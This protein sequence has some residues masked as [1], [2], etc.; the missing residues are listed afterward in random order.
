MTPRP[1]NRGHLAEHVPGARLE[2]FE[3]AAHMLNLE[4][5]ARFSCCAS[6]SRR[7]S[8]GFTLFLGD[9]PSSIH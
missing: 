8:P 2:L 1:W 3:G 6:S 7:S 5:P 9:V 4:Q